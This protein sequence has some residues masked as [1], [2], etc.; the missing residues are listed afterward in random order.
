[1]RAFEFLYEKEQPNLANIKTQIIGQVKKTQ[2]P[3]LLQKL[4]TT[5]NKGGLVDRIAPVLDRDTDTKGYVKDLVNMIIDV[6]GTYEEKQAFINEYP[7]GYIDIKKMLSGE[8]I[9]FTDLIVG[10]KD[11]PLQFVLRVFMALKQVTFGGAKGPGEFGLAVLSPH[12]K[13]TAGGD[14]KIGDKTIEVKALAGESAGGGGRVGTPGLLASDDV[15][16]KIKKHIPKFTIE[17]GTGLNLKQL[18]D[19]MS[20]YGL[21]PAKKRALATDLFNYIFRGQSDISGLVDAVVSGTDPNPYYLK[22]NY[23]IY[24]K[25]SNFDGMML[26]NFQTQALKY[27][28]DPLQ[29]ANEI[30]AMS[31]YLISSNPGFQTRQILSQV[32]LRRVKE[33]KTA[34]EV[35]N[36]PTKKIKPINKATDISQPTPQADTNTANKQIKNKPPI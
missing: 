14:L 13:I 23:E 12:I 36:T 21:S 1:M 27:F 20:V 18:S 25:E 32:S 24:Q 9:K 11:A 7:N 16:L 28:I 30:Y 35:A 29:M 22:A 3:D 34:P 33:P 5:L 15:P 8:Y 10:G 6:E 31:V 19:L 26:I 2:D 17:K 4:Y